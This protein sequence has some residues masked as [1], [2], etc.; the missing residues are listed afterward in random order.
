MAAALAVTAALTL[1]ACGSGAAAD[2]AAEAGPPRPGGTLRFAVSSDQGC[3]DPQQ[4]TS[5]D[6]VYSVRQLVDSLT[7]QDPATGEI[8]PWLATSWKPNAD[9]TAY[10]FTL[11][12]GVTF[13]DGSALDANAVKA[14]FDRVPSLGARATLPKGYL[15]GYQGTTVTSPTTF[16]VRF[17]KPNAQFL[18]A[19]S[20]HSL[21]I[22]APASAAKSDDQRCAGVVGSGPFVL[23]SYVKDQA[24]V[25]ARRAGYNWGSSLFHHQGEAYLDGAEF[26]VVPESGVRTGSL[27]AGE[28]DAVASIGPQDEAPLAGAGDA[29]PARA[30]PGLPFGITFNQATPLGSDPA[31]RE[32]VSLGVNR[33]E[34]V[35]A[36]FTSQTKPATSV[37]ASSTPSYSDN[38]ALLG[39]DPARAGAVLDAAGWKAG[40]DGIRAKG[41]QRLTLPIIFAN[42]LSTVKPALELLQQ[43]LRAVGVD[44]QL[45]EKQISDVPQLQQS[46]QFTAMWGNLTR[47]DP[48]ILR[49]SYVSNG[50]NYY[51]FKPGPLDA[52]L[53][54]Q[55]AA[56]DP[57]KRT[58]L[59]AQAQKLMLTEHLAV[60]VVE[61]TTTL[62]VAPGTHD[63]AFDA[64]SRIQLHDT[65]KSE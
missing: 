26:R 49:S 63:V 12:P 62:G 7:D 61:L 35:G 10:D 42:N 57:A 48:D 20:T 9:G 14:N 18:Q 33:P 39:F 44:A 23:S 46:G 5:N 50:T 38:S 21:G 59:V 4:V 56:V 11:R 29:L 58:E 6:S 2:P 40:P 30:N 19:I 13:S 52:L 55:A 51:R 22:L 41:G 36:V 65:W 43:Q 24:T 16:T 27:Q 37:L 8:R 17:G 60:P 54:G 45:Q 1:S 34:L 31:V 32:A 53:T 25:L 47:A 28:I 3:V 64:S 15:A